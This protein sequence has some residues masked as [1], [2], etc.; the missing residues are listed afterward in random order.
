MF[1]NKAKNF[2]DTDYYFITASFESNT[3][4]ANQIEIFIQ[5]S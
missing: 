2:D 1:R 4:Y 3:M 5:Q